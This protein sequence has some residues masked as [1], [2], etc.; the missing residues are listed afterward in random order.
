MS[1]QAPTSWWVWSPKGDSHRQV[2]EGSDPLGT[3]TTKAKQ[4][5]KQSSQVMTKKQSQEEVRITDPHTGGQ[6]GQKLAQL[7]ALDPASLMEVAKIAGFGAQKYERY[8][9]LL[10]FSWSLSYD[11]LQRHLHAF[12]NGED[13]DEE[14]GLFHLAHAAWQCLCL[15]SFSMR[16]L[17]TDDRYKGQSPP[18]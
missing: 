16:N 7:G 9:Y 17:G 3:R 8:N 10:G 11:A 4:E 14:S 6:K 12:W 1:S 15:L 5:E 13:V 2:W 18:M